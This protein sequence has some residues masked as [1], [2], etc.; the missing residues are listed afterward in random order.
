MV[1]R[2]SAF[3]ITVADRCAWR[4]RGWSDPGPLRVVL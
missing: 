3:F 4:H 2:I 1:R